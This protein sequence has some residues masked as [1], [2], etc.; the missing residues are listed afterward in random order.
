M[1]EYFTPDQVYHVVSHGR[2]F[3]VVVMPAGDAGYVAWCLEFPGFTRS[4]DDPEALIGQLTEH[5]DTVY[6]NAM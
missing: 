5:I 1:H 4:G 2:V 3:H 6:R